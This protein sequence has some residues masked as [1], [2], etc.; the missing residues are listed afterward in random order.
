MS[1]N[2]ELRRLLA[3]P[4]PGE[5]SESF[6]VHVLDV[7]G[8]GAADILRRTR[9]VLAI[10]LAQPAEPRPG[11]EQWRSLLPDWF[12]ASASRGL[13]SWIA[14]FAAAERPW[15]WWNGRTTAP[16]QLR[17]ELETDDWNASTDSLEQLLRAAGADTVVAEA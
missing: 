11:A 5:Q 3:G 7:R 1:S 16:D 9:E 14:G 10:V 8:D 4:W 6:A 13:E 17:I 15:T 12:V 2:A